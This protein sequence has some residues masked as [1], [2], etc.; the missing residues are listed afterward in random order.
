MNDLKQYLINNG[1]SLVAFADMSMVEGI[2]WRSGI[3]IA[4]NIKKDVVESISEG[5]TASY[6]NEYYR[7]NDRLD[8]LALLAASYIESMGHRAFTQT[9]EVVSEYGVY[10]TPVPHK[11]VA[12]R[13]GLGWIGKSAML[14]TKEFGPAVRIS[15]VLTD[16]VLEYDDS[17]DI[18]ECGECSRCKMYCPGSAISGRKWEV[19]VDRDEFF[20][21]LEC[22]REARRLSAERLNK[23]ITLCGKCIVVCPYTQQYLKT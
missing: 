1:A 21:P 5:P 15:S 12:T 14:V 16:M 18:S 3:S 23:E 2:G 19:G 20:N 4:M 22:R 17:I 6:Y 9:R 11:T 10:R 7:L 8:E 13:A